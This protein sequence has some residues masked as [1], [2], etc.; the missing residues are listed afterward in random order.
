MLDSAAAVA[1][2]VLL[3]SFF[4]GRWNQDGTYLWLLP[5]VSIASAALVAVVVIMS[6]VWTT[7]TSP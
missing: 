6:L 4:I 5:L 2:G 7:V 1:V 3:V